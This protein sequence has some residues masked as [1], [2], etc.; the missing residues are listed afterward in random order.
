MPNCRFST[1][2]KD[3]LK[4]HRDQCKDTS[5]IVCKKVCY[6]LEEPAFDDF[7]FDESFLDDPNF[8]F[9]TFDL[10]TA[11]VYSDIAEAKLRILSIGLY[12]NIDEQQ[13][14]YERESSNV[15]DGQKMVD[16]FIERL[17]ILATLFQANLPP[18]I[19]DELERIKERFQLLTLDS[20]S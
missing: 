2:R 12:S 17:F 3:K 20:K 1:Q 4:R 6:G 18:Q 10:E 16:Q 8:K 7:D 9:A 19:I 5:Q 14:Y 13:Y 15:E 11:E